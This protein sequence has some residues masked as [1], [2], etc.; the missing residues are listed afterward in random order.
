MNANKLCKSFSRVATASS[1]YSYIFISDAIV[2]T[3]WPF[4][5]RR[6]QYFKCRIHTWDAVHKKI[7]DD[8]FWCPSGPRSKGQRE[9]PLCILDW[10]MPKLGNMS[11]FFIW[12]RAMGKGQ[13]RES[14]LSGSINVRVTPFTRRPPGNDEAHKPVPDA[15]SAVHPLSI[16][17]VFGWRP[18]GLCRYPC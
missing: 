13:W 14:I 3:S 10:P 6:G 1:N 11:R 18:R 15:P 7:L 8:I 4:S 12:A 9:V 16:L 5:K 17:A 2:S